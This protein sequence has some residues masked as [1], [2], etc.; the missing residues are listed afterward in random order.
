MKALSI[1]QP[2]ADMITTGEKSLEFRSRPTQHRGKLVICSSNFDEGYTVEIAGVA[3]PLPLGM[4]LSVVEIIDCR[5]VTTEDLNHAGAPSMV[6]G[7][8]WE[9]SDIVDVLIPAPVLGRVNFF[10][11]P[12]DQIVSALPNKYWY[13]YL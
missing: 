7:Y 6:G 2:W 5:P 10:D 12:D 11:V 3:R 13:D 9:F 1:R 8:A 4:M